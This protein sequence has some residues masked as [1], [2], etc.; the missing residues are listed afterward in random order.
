MTV[1]RGAAPRVEAE[2]A[3]PKTEARGPRLVGVVL[4][5]TFC[6]RWR[7]W[8]R[9]LW[10]CLSQTAPCVFLPFLPSLPASD[11]QRHEPR[12]FPLFHLSVP[13][14]VAEPLISWPWGLPRPST[15]MAVAR[16]YFQ[17][18][19]AWVAGVSQACTRHTTE[20]KPSP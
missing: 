13:G 7:S 14:W 2:R 9:V 5:F 19:L 20:Y 18:A 15:N 16:F 17:K 12:S 1:T 4:L 6:A 3:W 8:W 10:E 11:F